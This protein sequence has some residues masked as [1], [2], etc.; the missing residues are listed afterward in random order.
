VKPKD[1][2]RVHEQTLAGI[3]QHD[4]AAGALKERLIDDILQPLHLLAERGLRPADA[5]G[6]AAQRPHFRD[7]GERSQQFDLKRKTQDIRSSSIS[8]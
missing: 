7:D 4:A 6:R 2:L 8:H 3:R 5:L 1:A